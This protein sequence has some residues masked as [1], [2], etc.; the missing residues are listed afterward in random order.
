MECLNNTRECRFHSRSRLAVIKLPK[1]SAST[2]S[3][4][5]CLCFS[6]FPGM[7]DAY[8][9]LALIAANK[10]GLAASTVKR[11]MPWSRRRR[12]DFQTHASLLISKTRRYMF[13]VGQAVRSQPTSLMTCG[14]VKWCL[15]QG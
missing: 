13:A 15:L 8:G 3:R 6:R 1:V 11:T 5:A 7:S 4:R 2:S 12:C 9:H 14:L 10:E